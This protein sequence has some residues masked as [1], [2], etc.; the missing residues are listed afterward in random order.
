MWE[1]KLFLVC[2]QDVG[3]YVTALDKDSGET[4][5]TA[6]RPEFDGHYAVDVFVA[7]IPKPA[8]FGL[9]AVGG[10]KLVRRRRIA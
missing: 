5:W 6:E 2:D 8:T 9:L 7:I 3:S 1:S 10:V 4:L